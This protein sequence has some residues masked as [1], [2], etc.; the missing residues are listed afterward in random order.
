MAEHYFISVDS[1]Q[2]DFIVLNGD[3]QLTDELITEE[4]ID[5][6]EINNIGEIKSMAWSCN[7][8]WT[9]VI[10]PDCIYLINTYDNLAVRCKKKSWQFIE[11]YINANRQQT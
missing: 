7:A 6:V 8:K 4:D 11:L 9:F 3:E 5:F 1:K 10:Q 2:K